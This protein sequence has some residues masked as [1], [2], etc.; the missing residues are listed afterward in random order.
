M[1]KDAVTEGE[2][3]RD[4]G[5]GGGRGRRG[6][7]GGGTRTLVHRAGG[8]HSLLLLASV[9]EPN[10]NHL[11]PNEQTISKSTKITQPL[12]QKN[13]FFCLRPQALF[14][15]LEKLQIESRGQGGGGV[16]FG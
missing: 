14:M 15:D 4:R 3:G 10:S 5:G 8:I 12:R 2:E 9:A 13:A 6:G 1:T 16:D 11:L 7:G